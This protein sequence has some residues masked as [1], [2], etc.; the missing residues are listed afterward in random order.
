MTNLV[1]INWTL[2]SFHGWGVLGVNLALAL[3]KQGRLPVPLQETSLSLTDADWQHMQPALEAGTEIRALMTEASSFAVGFP[4]LQPVGNALR[5]DQR[6]A[7]TPDLGITFFE[8]THLD[9]EAILRGQSLSCLIT[10]CRWA[11]DILKDKGFANSRVCYQG[12]DPRLYFHAPAQKTRF[13]GRFVVF[14][15]GKLEFRKGQDIALEGFKR[16]HARHPDSLL[17]T[18]WQ[19][20]WPDSAANIARGRFAKAAPKAGSTA[21]LDIESWVSAHDLPKDAHAEIGFLAHGLLPDLL[22]QADAALFTSRAES[23]TNL[24]AMEALALGLPTIL[25][26]NTGH[27][28]LIASVPCL[29]LQSQA[30]VTPTMAE[31]GVVG[32]GDSDP[33]EI[34]ALL[35]ECYAQRTRMEEMGRAAAKAMQDW[36]WERRMEAMIEGLGLGGAE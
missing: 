26:A 4:V 21:P 18:A 14:S 33:D 23:G 11:D 24:M 16:F 2:S 20:P 29:A 1:G 15:G 25:S 12:V 19:N 22:R 31:D 13:P 34:A 8:N 9:A 30:P 6:V 35:E 5:W 7:G 28:D 10:G 36:S 17:L 27:L 32:W 3:L